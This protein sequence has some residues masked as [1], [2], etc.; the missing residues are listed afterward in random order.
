MRIT[1]YMWKKLR[2]R[3]QNVDLSWFNINYKTTGNLKELKKGKC[4]MKTPSLKLN[5]YWFEQ[6]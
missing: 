2:D 4:F 3:F 5:D 6:P 1:G